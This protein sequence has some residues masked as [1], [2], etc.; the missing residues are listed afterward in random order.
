M[1]EHIKLSQKKKKKRC[2]YSLCR[3][4]QGLSKPRWTCAWSPQQARCEL[5]CWL[6]C[7]CEES[8]QLERAQ[9]P[10]GTAHPPGDRMSRSCEWCRYRWQWCLFLL[11]TLG[12]SFSSW[13][14][15]F[16]PGTRRKRG[17]CH[18]PWQRTGCVFINIEG[19][20]SLSPGRRFICTR[21]PSGSRT[22]SQQ[23]STSF[24]ISSP[25]PHSLNNAWKWCLD[26]LL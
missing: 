14:Q 25:G 19:H 9:T 23:T 16:P 6:R 11:G 1:K 8:P 17:Q 13:M 18:Q 24:G 10:W 12:S 5:H 7:K 20:T 4:Q 3:G 21:R 15:P 22:S 26:E 2:K